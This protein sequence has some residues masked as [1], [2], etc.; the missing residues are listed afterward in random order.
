MCFFCTFYRTQLWGD[1]GTP[2]LGLSEF[3]QSRGAHFGVKAPTAR[4]LELPPQE[5]EELT[6][7]ALLEFPLLHSSFLLL[8]FKEVA[9]TPGWLP[10]IL[11]LSQLVFWQADTLR[12]Q[13]VTLAAPV[14][15][16]HSY[17]RKVAPD[18][19]LSCLSVHVRADLSQLSS[20]CENTYQNLLF[21]SNCYTTYIVGGE[22][23]YIFSRQ[24]MFN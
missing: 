18:S 1:V 14:L 15:Q 19:G 12:N 13:I 23:I 22:N 17:D 4:P 8:S 9:M 21:T 16:M 20:L 11:I 5:G 7:V 10:L 3:Q 6:K 2:V 24:I